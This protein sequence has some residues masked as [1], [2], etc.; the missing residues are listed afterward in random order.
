MKLIT[1][2]ISFLINEPI[3]DYTSFLSN[4]AISR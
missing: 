2:L 1:W 4:G 3:K